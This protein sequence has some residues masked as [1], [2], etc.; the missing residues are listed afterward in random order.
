MCPPVVAAAAT[1]VSMAS[2]ITQY[3]G[4]Q[5]AYSANRLAANQNY[6]N[7]ANALRCGQRL[8]RN[9]PQGLQRRVC[10]GH[11]GHWQ[12]PR[13]LQ[14]RRQ[15]T[16]RSP[17]RAFPRRSPMPRSRSARTSKSRP[18]KQRCSAAGSILS[19]QTS[20]ARQPR[21]ALVASQRTPNGAPVGS[22]G[23]SL[24]TPTSLMRT[25]TAKGGP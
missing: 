19:A 16:L 5:Q 1:A 24:G 21:L 6:A 8:S 9:A 7:K 15:W 2:T 17:Q 23:S 14:Q 12:H 11:A 18:T 25:G 20:T 3:V 10:S 22:Y 4:Q 13:P